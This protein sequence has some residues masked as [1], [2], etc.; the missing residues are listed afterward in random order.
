MT[1]MAW[2]QRRND[3]Q[4][5]YAGRVLP[6]HRPIVVR[7]A[8]EH[9]AT[10]D[11]QVSSITA[12]NLLARMTP[13]V[14]L[15]IPDIG[16]AQPLP[17]AGS[18]LRETLIELARGADPFAAFEVRA[19]REGDYVLTIGRNE[20]PNLVHGSG[21]NA[22]VGPGQSPIPEAGV[23]NPIGPALAAIVAVA[24]L[25]ALEMRP[26]DGPFVLNAFDWGNGL[27]RAPSFIDCDLGNI[28]AIGAGSVGTAALY[29][30]SLATHRFS[31]VVFDM[32]DVKV[33][34]LDRSPIF[35]AEDAAEKRNKADVTVDYLR[36]VGVGNASAEHDP[37]DLS[38][39]WMSRSAE[40]PDLVIAAANE[41]NVRYII[42]Q[43]C[44]PLQIYGTTGANWNAS[45]MRHIPTMGAC[46]CCIFPPD[47]TQAAMQCATG[48]VADSRTGEQ[49]DAALPFLSFATG[50]MT[51][52]EILKVNFPG[53]PFGP[54]RTVFSLSAAT[55][56]RF[57]SF[58][59]TTRPGCVCQS[60][61]QELHGKMI[62]GTR[63]AHLSAKKMTEFNLSKEGLEMTKAL[64]E[65]LDGRMR[66]RDGEIRQKRSDTLV[67]TLRR[68]YGEN[69]A[70]GYRAD[71][72]LGTVLKRE[73]I[74]TLDQLRK[75]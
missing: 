60:R 50:L 12:V 49:V 19:P 66:D 57:T 75:R 7:L 67:G 27:S 69:F 42:E 48:I 65:G 24:R 16:L 33:E 9:A 38:R 3:R 14:V 71:T 63:Y 11:G 51:A 61:S 70:G 43:S 41:R 10:F 15:D 39:R 46:S 62:A 72:K 53:Y 1:D 2:Y 5:R 54:D 45:V 29:F 30:L 32:D 40:E 64:S 47:M 68:E 74:N 26:L 52:A 55:Q 25:F 44:P 23:P 34:N 13:A 58:S 28:W 20:A 8:P 6:E 18:S 37:L 56:P 22:F 73:G 21:W 4:M 36:H 35:H 17:L 31:T 59:T